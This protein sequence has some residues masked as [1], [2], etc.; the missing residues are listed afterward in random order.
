MNLRVPGP[1]P[2]P[3][4][5]IEAMSRQMVSHRGD[6]FA[7]I[8][9]E[10]TNELKTFFQTSN[11]V[12]IL[13]SSGTGGLEAAVVNF[14]SPGDRIL[15]VSIGYF[16]ER[17][18]AIARAYGATMKELEFPW[19]E[20]A[21]PAL[22]ER[23]LTADPTIKAV[24]VTHNE[25]STGVTNDLAAISE[26]VKPSGAL[27]IVDAISSLGAI[28]LPVDD[29]GI[30]ICVTCSQK[31]WMTPPGLAMIS[32]SDRAWAAQREAQMPRFYMD[33]TQM[34]R[35]AAKGSTPF[36]PA[37]SL[38]YALKE[39]LRLMSEEGRK[40]ILQRHRRLGERTR[41]GIK[42]LGLEL[43]ANENYASNTV[44]AVKV[45][46]GIDGELVGQQLLERYG[47]AIA[48]G[49]G[50]LTGKIWRIAHLG[51]VSEDD[52]DQTVAALGAV[53]SQLGFRRGA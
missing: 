11:D 28:P 45:P 26:A 9:R 10:V 20:A 27:L 43:F 34:K 39:A 8:F 53:L 16:G 49:S 5:V 51:Y 41:Q 3:P 15:G 7:T 36:T 29:W 13:A 37:V 30:D 19:G 52:I 24:L 1:T 32:V 25:T 50:K 31:A 6:E 48:E 40:N 22:I 2:L 42:A 17:F 47:V 44:T 14:L 46:D 35:A 4:S 21:D 12:L 18:L 38:F 23:E 33:L